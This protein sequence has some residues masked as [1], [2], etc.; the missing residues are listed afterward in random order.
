MN[1][2]D[3]FNIFVLMITVAIIGLGNVGT[4]L[5]RAF[6]NTNNIKVIHLDSRNLDNIS[7]VDVTIIA[8][9][10]D[11][12][13]EVSK[14][15]NTS[16]VVHTSGSVSI[17][18]LQNSGR[19]G[20]FY[21]LQTFTKGTVVAFDNIPICLEV[22]NEKDMEI[23]ETLAL[24]ISER[25]YHI[26]SL[27]RKH[28]HVSAVFVNNFVN[29]MYT[30]AQNICEEHDVPFEILSPL[31]KETADKIKSIAPMEAQ[32]GPAKRND[33]KTI[34]KHLD[35]LNK[36]QQE[37]YRKLTESIQAYGKKL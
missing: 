23:L 13:Q 2:I 14:Q 27:Q 32:T 26:N 9:S 25:F 22:E 20:V 15:L 16:L 5:Y 1:M 7:N 21:P 37:I 18:E 10:D 19:K 29:H 17:N 8:V 6:K 24:S 36:E 30:I 4:H 11:A 35:L 31:I 12:I 34:Q 28:I 3:N 33:V